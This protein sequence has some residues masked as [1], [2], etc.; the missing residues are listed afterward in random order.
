MSRTIRAS[1]SPSFPATPGIRFTV[2]PCLVRWG[3]CLSCSYVSLLVCLIMTE[4]GLAEI[5]PTN[6]SPTCTTSRPPMNH[7]NNCGHVLHFDVRS[8]LITA[9]RVV[10]GNKIIVS[11][12]KSRCRLQSSYFSCNYRRNRI[13]IGLCA[14]YPISR[15]SSKREGNHPKK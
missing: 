13:Q 8:A 9:N 10:D 6:P 7:A 15:K 5:C 11:R 14:Q 12:K 1:V 4:A 2:F 3:E